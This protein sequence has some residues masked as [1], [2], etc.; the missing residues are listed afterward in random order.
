MFAEVEVAKSKINTESDQP[1]DDDGW[2]GTVMHRLYDLIDADG[3]GGAEHDT[4]GVVITHPLDSTHCH[5]YEVQ[6]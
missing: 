3:A 5:A 6:I 1:V 4:S 2:I